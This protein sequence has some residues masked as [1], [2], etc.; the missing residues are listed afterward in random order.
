MQ[1]YFGLRGSK[2]N[3]AIWALACF[4]I[5][6]FGYNQAVAGGVLTSE[7]F[8]KQFP[9]MD[10]VDTE[11]A[12]K[13]HNATIQGTVLGI[14]V[15][16]GVF[17]S[18]ACTFLGDVWGRRWTIFA[19][20]A[21]E[22]VGV[23]LMGSSF[24]F[25][26]FIVSRILVGLGTGGVIATTSVW[27]AELSK[28]HSRGSHVSGFGIFCGMGLS[29][30]LWI[31]FG[32]HYVQSS[33]AWRFPFLI[34]I[35]LSLTVM[36]FIFTLPESPRWLVKMGR[37][38]EAKGIFSATYEVDTDSETVSTNIR[39]IQ[40]SIE[41]AQ[42]AS[43]GALFKMGKQR[44]LHRVVLA[45]TIQMYLQMTGVNSV[46][47]YAST[48]FQENLGYP[49]TKADILAA[50]SQIV[51]ILGS[52]VCSYT[53]DRFGR[54]T[55]MLLSAAS[56]S[57]CQIALTALGSQPQN[58]GCLKASVFF[59]YL[60]YFV[61]VLGFLG[62]PFLYA[63]EIAPVHL[64]AAVCGIS[65]AVSWLFNFLVV[66]ITPVAFTTIGYRYFVVFAAVNA[67]SIPVVYFFYPETRGRSLEEIDEIFTKSNSVLEPVKVAK[68]LPQ[69]HLTEMVQADEK[70]GEGVERLEDIGA[71][72]K[73]KGGSDDGNGSVS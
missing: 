18:L 1:P 50:S 36:T 37:I 73:E 70:T 51:I 49:T 55:L 22:L 14:Y 42:N 63:S 38:D 57:T 46:T 61:Y 33:F 45:A 12:E 6:I 10:T 3:A 21:T 64:R 41:I 66:E 25:A 26:Q 40:L 19:A 17:G 27:Q 7:S 62:V 52:I 54:R 43:L 44:T 28:P 68:R 4:C 9:Q 60:Y 29:L 67:S 32:A 30:A 2:L 72:E 59:I 20:T 35:I 24:A 69:K 8:Q 31:D 16:A 34:Q 65:T 5:M 56:M 15:L 58:T 71:E 11:G 13:K 53:V 47:S 48:I 39:D 23:V